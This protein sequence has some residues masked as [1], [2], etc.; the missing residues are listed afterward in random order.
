MDVVVQAISGSM[1]THREEVEVKTLFLWCEHPLH[2]GREVGGRSL[3]ANTTVHWDTLTV[4]HAGRVAGQEQD[5]LR[6]FLGSTKLT[7]EGRL[8]LGQLPHGVNHSIHVDHIP[9][10]TGRH[11]RGIDGVDAHAWPDQNRKKKKV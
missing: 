10:E 1:Y 8:P 7:L 5:D 9:G 2:Q 3:Q 4:H 6:L 11:I